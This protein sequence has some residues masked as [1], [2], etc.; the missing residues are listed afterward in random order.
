M[1]DSSQLPVTPDA[2]DPMFSLGT[3]THVVYN[4]VDTHISHKSYLLNYSKKFCV[5]I[6]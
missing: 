1:M 5:D 4:H 3:S 6:F 2:G